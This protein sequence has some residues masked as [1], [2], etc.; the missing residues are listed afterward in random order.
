MPEGCCGNKMGDGLPHVSHKDAMLGEA[1]PAPSTCPV[2]RG[3]SEGPHPFTLAGAWT[4]RSGISCGD[5]LKGE[6]RFVGCGA[7]IAVAD[8]KP[9]ADCPESSVFRGQ[10]A[11]G[12]RTI[13]LEAKGE[14]VATPHV[15]RRARSQAPPYLIP[16]G[17]VSRTETLRIS[18][19]DA[20]CLDLCPPGVCRLLG[21][22]TV[23]YENT[24]TV[25]LCHW[26][27]LTDA[28]S[29]SPCC[30]GARGLEGTRQGTTADSSMPF[31]L[32]PFRC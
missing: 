23:T 9:Y 21:W 28:N 26:Y 31:A 20:P 8:C 18:S 11:G 30:L 6:E 14:I 7:G 32:S 19:R 29:S 16:R 22:H 13:S 1:I 5:T 15:T 10:T 3:T 17:S 27:D 25:P 24:R 12:W 4:L 2:G